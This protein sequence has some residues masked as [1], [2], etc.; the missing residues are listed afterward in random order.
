M[1]AAEKKAADDKAAAEKAELERFDKHPRF[2]E[3]HKQVKDLQEQLKA[4]TEVVGYAQTLRD[5]ATI[6]RGRYPEVRAIV[7][8]EMDMRDETPALRLGHRNVYLAA[9]NGHCWH[10]TQSADEASVFILTQH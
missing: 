3:L 1:A 2:Q 6:L 5:A 8:D 10:V 4:A 7:V 9:S